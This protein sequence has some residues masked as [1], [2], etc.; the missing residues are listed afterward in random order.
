MCI[1]YEI[2]FFLGEEGVLFKIIGIQ[3]MVL[4]VVLRINLEPKFKIAGYYL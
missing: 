1:L 4:L 3:I 2:N